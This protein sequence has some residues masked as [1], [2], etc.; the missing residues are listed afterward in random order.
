M[1][2]KSYVLE[3]TVLCIGNGLASPVLRTICRVNIGTVDGGT[4]KVLLEQLCRCKINAETEIQL[5]IQEGEISHIID[6]MCLKMKA[7]SKILCKLTFKN[8]FVFMPDESVTFF[9]HLVSWNRPVIPVYRLTL[10]TCY[11]YAIENKNTGTRLYKQS[12]TYVAAI[13]YSRAIKYLVTMANLNGT[14]LDDKERKETLAICHLNLAACLLKLRLYSEVI[15]NCTD[16]LEIQSCNIKALYRR[17]ESYLCLNDFEKAEKDIGLGLK[18]DHKNKAFLKL[19]FDLKERT[20]FADAQLSNNLKT[21]F[22]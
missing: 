2:L 13:F 4:S 18:L 1:A 15:C 8:D 12:R 5:G 16:T 9:L 22:L 7:D 10:D 3:K 11:F 17:A 20:S 6:S 19:K 14:E 21:L